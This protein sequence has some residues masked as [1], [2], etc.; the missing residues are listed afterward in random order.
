MLIPIIIWV[1]KVIAIVLLIGFF[2]IILFIL[3]YYIF[4]F[5]MERVPEEVESNQKQEPEK[6]D[7]EM[8]INDFAVKVA[9]L[10]GGKKSINIAQI[11]EVLK[12]VNQLLAGEL[13]KLIRKI[14]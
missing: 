9:K 10:E 2:E 8:N 3:A 6:G 7:E 13:Y 5:F 4:H 1:G 12:I 11:K 14:K